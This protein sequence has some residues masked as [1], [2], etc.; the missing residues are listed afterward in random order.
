MGLLQ[1]EVWKIDKGSEQ[2]VQPTNQ[3]VFMAADGCGP[4]GTKLLET[5]PSA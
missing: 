2:L 5:K 4:L 3:R 1:L